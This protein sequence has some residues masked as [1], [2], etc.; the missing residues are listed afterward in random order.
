MSNAAASPRSS[1]VTLTSSFVFWTAAVVQLLVFRGLRRGSL[2]DSAVNQFS[3]CC[4]RSVFSSEMACLCIEG[5]RRVSGALPW[6]CG[7]DVNAGSRP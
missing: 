7:G 3:W 4:C 6:R 1:S 5:S 2:A